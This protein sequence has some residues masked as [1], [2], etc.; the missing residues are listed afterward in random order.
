MTAK[1][2]MN[3]VIAIKL[4]KSARSRRMSHLQ[5][6]SIKAIHSVD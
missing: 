4:D 5:I 6:L 1:L 3:P 2:N